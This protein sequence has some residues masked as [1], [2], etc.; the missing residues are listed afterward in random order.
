MKNSLLLAA[1]IL[2]LSACAT[3]PEP[4]DADK[5]ISAAEKEV[6][7]AK[8]SGNLWNNTEKFLDEAKKAKKEGDIAGAIKNAKKATDE[9][10]LA[11]V[12]KMD[13]A[14]PKVHFPN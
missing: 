4:A 3:A 11:Q 1:V 14:N 2:G 8:K 10:K 12:Q 6:A 9:A 13:Q 5:A 7:A